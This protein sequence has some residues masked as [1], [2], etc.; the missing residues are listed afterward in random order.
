MYLGELSIVQNEPSWHIMDA[1]FMALMAD[2]LLA[3]AY[4]KDTH[5]TE[6]R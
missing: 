6:K 2:G 1:S 5:S 3:I 4:D